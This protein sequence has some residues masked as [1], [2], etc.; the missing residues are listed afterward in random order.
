MDKETKSYIKF[1]EKK[2]KEQ[3]K[4][5]DELSKMIEKLM[6]DNASLS[7]RVSSLEIDN[8]LLKEKVYKDDTIKNIP[9]PDTGKRYFDPPYRI[10]C[11]L[12]RQYENTFGNLDSKFW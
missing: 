6:M 10:T 7:S 9:I 1:L 8:R 2:I 12:S 5:N 4:N 11:N 3:E